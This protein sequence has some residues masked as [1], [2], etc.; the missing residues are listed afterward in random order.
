MTDYALHPSGVQGYSATARALH[1]ITAVLVLFLLAAGLVMVRM[2]EGPAQV[3]LFDLHRSVGALL[4]PIIAIRLWYRLTH[5]PPPLPADIAPIQRLAAEA[6]HWG[7][8]AALVV[9]PMLGWIGM[10]AFGH[11]IR[12]FWLF[13][14]PMIWPKDEAFSE[15]LF[16]IHTWLGYAIAAM[17]SAH[18]G[19]ALFHHFIRRDTVLMRMLR[20]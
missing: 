8:Y 12:M 18:I 7:L 11:P 14:L 9:Q 1:W 19:G 16:K 2:P 15:F 17:V 5:K 6:T 13:D 20:S 10:S 4:I 3:T